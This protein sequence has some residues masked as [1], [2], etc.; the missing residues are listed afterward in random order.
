MLAS[1]NFGN[2]YNILVEQRTRNFFSIEGKSR[3][4]SNG[5]AIQCCWKCRKTFGLKFCISHVQ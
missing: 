5:Y 4:N 3:E 1:I 2:F